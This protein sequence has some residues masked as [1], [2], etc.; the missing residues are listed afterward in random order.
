MK[1]AT[2][3][4][5][6]DV[7]LAGAALTCF[8]LSVF[9]MC[10][11]GWWVP[12]PAATDLAAFVF[13]PLALTFLWSLLAGANLAAGACA[14]VKAARSRPVPDYRRIAELEAGIFG[15]DGP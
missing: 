12:N 15:G 2:R 11:D 4:L 14:A 8:G 3:K 13:I 9:A 1:Q 7:K 10:A 5:T 6:G